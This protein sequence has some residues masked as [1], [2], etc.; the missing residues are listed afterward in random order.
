MAVDIHLNIADQDLVEEVLV[1][2]KAQV[3]MCT[4]SS[5]S[6]KANMPT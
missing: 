6:I 1:Y 3:G 5:N 4:P 2:A